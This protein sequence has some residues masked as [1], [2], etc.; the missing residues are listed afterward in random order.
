MPGWG[1]ILSIFSNALALFRKV[2]EIIST[3]IAKKAGRDE[4]NADTLRQNAERTAEAKKVGDEADRIHR[5]NP[6][7]DDKAFDTSF[8]RD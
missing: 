2:A 3:S 5:E 7:D 6:D 4:A 1:T 8:R